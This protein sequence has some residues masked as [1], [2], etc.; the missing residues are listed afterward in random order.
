MSQRRAFLLAI[1]GPAGAG[2]ST[3]SREVAKR[4]GFVM[5]DTGALYRAVA[6][7]AVR[8][9]VAFDDDV[10]LGALLA[11]LE[12]RVESL[13]GATSRTFL[14]GEDVSSAIRTQEIS[15]AA[16]LVSSR[17]V[18]RE[19]LLALQRR[20]AMEASQGAVLEGRDIGTVVFPG[21][22]AKFFLTA[23]VECRAK[24]RYEELVEKGAQ[25]RFEEV[26]EDQ[27]QRDRRDMER[28]LA[29]LRPAEDAHVVDSSD[30]TI[31][32]VVDEIVEVATAKLAARAP[33]D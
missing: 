17:P 16:S 28:E 30:R 9:A 14:W 1:D 20:L 25:V 5:V 13:P 19:G 22:D 26:L 11:R 10:G 7:A 31:P 3:V 32:E 23:S 8:E 27:R 15:S 18:V 12:V 21:A 33:R 4:L 29:P 6:L 24:R 2:K